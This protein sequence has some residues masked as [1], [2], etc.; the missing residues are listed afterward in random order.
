MKKKHKI[1]SLLIDEFS[2][3]PKYLQLVNSVLNLIKQG[4]LKKGDLMPSINELSF[5][6]GISRLTIEKGYN[7][8]KKIGV[9][10]AFPGKGSF[11][12]STD[13]LQD[14]RI[15]LMFNKL[16]SHKKIIY[17]SFIETL[18]DKASISLFIYNNDFSLFEKLLNQKKGDYSHYV[19]IPHF[20]D[21]SGEY[22]KLIENIPKEKLIIVGKKIE[23]IS[24]SYAAVYE[25]FE[26]DIYTSLMK[27]LKSLRKYHTLKLIFPEVSYL[28]YEIIKGFEKFCF[29]FDFDYKIV[30]DINL[31]PVNRGEV[32]INLLEEDL[33][34]V[35]DKILDQNLTIGVEVGVISYNETPLKKFI[36]NGLTT[37]STDFIEMGKT[38]ARLVLNSSKEQVENPFDIVFRG[39]L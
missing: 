29:S 27:A 15:F 22:Q 1:E 33:V 35:L 2:S 39:S 11:I 31:E 12:A 16:S 25:N 32:F 4:E 7:H 28:P 8:L 19:I 30:K 3:I 38:A 5:E 26:K 36:M 9:L 37:I 20:I 13:V 34:R 21:K 17:D 10:G 14:L 23:G 18:Q 24:G 6:Y